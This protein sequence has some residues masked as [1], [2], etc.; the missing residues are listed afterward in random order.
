MNDITT[1]CE[2]KKS[3]KNAGHQLKKV[4]RSISPQISLHSFILGFFIGCVLIILL[5]LY[6]TSTC[7][8]TF[9][10]SSSSNTEHHYIT[11]NLNT[12]KIDTESALAVHRD[13]R[14]RS[15]GASHSKKRQLE[16][17]TVK[18]TH[19]S[20]SSNSS[21]SCTDRIL[22][23]VILVL[24]SPQGFI[25]RNAIRGSWLHAYDTRKLKVTSRFLV[26]TL[27]LEQS[28]LDKIRLE[29]QKFS[30]M[31]LLDDV[32]DMYSNLS[33]KV[34]LGLNWAGR[35]L[36]HFDMLIKTDDDSYVQIEK[37]SDNFK[38]MGCPDR[39]YW[40]YF[41]GH[42]YPESK[43]KWAE[44][45]WFS[46]PHYL[47]Y[48]MG[49]GYILSRRIVHLLVHLSDRL[50]VYSNED[51]SLSS[52]LAPFNLVRRHDMRFNVESQS[53]GCHNAYLITHKISAQQLYETKKNLRTN[54]TLCSLEKEVRPGYNYNWSVSPLD[55]CNRIKGLPFT[56]SV[57]DI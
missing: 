52:W 22:H 48:A 37:V 6:S 44:R 49:G 15:R 55:C 31:L 29:A 34:L 30:D 36:G 28:V 32:K 54:G 39:L 40:G 51:V 47:P 9:C 1:Q 16:Q 46:C 19:S 3:N 35:E 11:R 45:S 14:H 13:N 5:G 43:G 23:V 33:K 2:L 50:T 7:L 8:G 25:R 56:V 24:S 18:V 10:T 57:L 20:K 42:A 27:E 38:E 12:R 53:H 4:Y 26:G 21:V 41:M 17:E